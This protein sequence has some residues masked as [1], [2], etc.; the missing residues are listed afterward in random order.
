[1]SRLDAVAAKDG[2]EKNRT[3]DSH[4]R[5]SARIHKPTRINTN[6]YRQTRW[7]V[8][9]GPRDC[10][11][12][13]TGI[14]IIPITKLTDA[15]RKWMLTAEFGGSGGIPIE[16]GMVVEEPDI[17]IG[18]GVSSKA[19]SR[20]MQTDQGGKSGP[21]SSHHRD[22]DEHGRSRRS[23]R[24]RDDRRDEDRNDR[25]PAVSGPPAMPAIPP[26][27][28]GMGNFSNF[29]MPTFHNGAP[30]MLPGFTFPGQ[31]AAP[32]QSSTS[33]APGRS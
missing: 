21:K 13:T 8:G 26:F 17:E 23:G 9:F 27:G 24:D 7:G 20:R 22:E 11:D 30:M 10:S 19:I 1:M 29:P 32:G 12:Y 25:F 4:L 18:Q 28:M 31:P 3:P 15:D 6:L 14:S 2:M 16:G 5:V 33:S